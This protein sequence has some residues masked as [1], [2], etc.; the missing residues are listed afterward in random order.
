MNDLPEPPDEN[1]AG[2]AKTRRLIA[3]GG[4]LTLLVLVAGYVFLLSLA[5]NPGT[6]GG[7]GAVTPLAAGFPVGGN[8]TTSHAGVVNMQSNSYYAPRST[9]PIQPALL[10]TGPL[11]QAMNGYMVTLYPWYADS[12]RI[13]LTYTVQSSFESLTEPAFG[14]LY[15]EEPRE[16]YEPRLTAGNSTALHGQPSD[17]PAIQMN[18]NCSALVFDVRDLNLPSKLKMHLVLNTIEF[19][20]GNPR[21]GWDTHHVRGPFNFDFSLPVDN[22][23]RVADLNQTARTEDG[24]TLAIERVI[25]THHEV[26]LIWRYDEPTQPVPTRTPLLRWTGLEFYQCCSLEVHAGTQSFNPIAHGFTS[27]KSIRGDDVL[28]ASLMDEQ[29]EWTISTWYMSFSSRNMVDPPRPGPVFRFT[30]PPPVNSSKQQK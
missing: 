20:A 3:V 24:G 1:E 15:G 5:S 30:M 6:Q 17:C 11:V 13:A 8:R 16:A 29:G 14:A 10:P 23:Q 7:S 27:D 18:E 25:V 12:I 9:P 21:A 22:A 2:K 26:R 19:L 4:G 28:T